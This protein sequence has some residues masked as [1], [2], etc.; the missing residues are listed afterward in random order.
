MCR[1]RNAREGV[2]YECG[3][4]ELDEYMR[5]LFRY[6]MVVALGSLMAA[7]SSAR[8]IPQPILERVD[9]TVLAG[10]TVAEDLRTCRIEVYKA[11]PVSIQ[12]R[13]L[14][15]IGAMANGV[16]L[17]TVEFP[18]PVW[19]SREAYRHAIELCLTARGYDVRGW[20]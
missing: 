20:Q 9:H 19:P 1:C 18:H 2:K 16:V 4:S 7:C 14:P 15:P 3:V 13:W 11:A 6:L 5:V 17:G 12:P 8:H 10:E